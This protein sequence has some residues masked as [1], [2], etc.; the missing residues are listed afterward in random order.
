M[1]SVQLFL[2]ACM[3]ETE[4]NIYTLREQKLLFPILPPILVPSVQSG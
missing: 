3:A 2:C 1:F 4:L